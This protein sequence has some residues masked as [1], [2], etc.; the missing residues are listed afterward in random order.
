MVVLIFI[1]DVSVMCGEPLL[2]VFVVEVSVIISNVVRLLAI[3]E[4]P[5]I[6]KKN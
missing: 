1:I 4:A 2:S 3:T 6:A 5:D